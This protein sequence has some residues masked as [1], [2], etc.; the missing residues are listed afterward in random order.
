MS[1]I[2]NL[3][4]VLDPKLQFGGE[5]SKMT[6]DNYVPL[7]AHCAPSPSAWGWELL[8]VLAD[9]ASVV[10]EHDFEEWAQ[11]AFLGGYSKLG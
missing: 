3:S 11:L 8:R 4:V 1:K 2:L 6:P 9:G 5:K 7:L 10:I